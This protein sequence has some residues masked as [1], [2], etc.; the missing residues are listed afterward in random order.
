MWRV[1][2]VEGEEKWETS[3]RTIGGSGG[4]KVYMCLECK[5]TSN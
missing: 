4:V 2:D 5:H 1:R 3:L